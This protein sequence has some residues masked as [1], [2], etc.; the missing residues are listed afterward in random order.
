ML[1]DTIDKIIR[2]QNKNDW[3][4]CIELCRKVLDERKSFGFSDNFGIYLSLAISLLSIEE[5][6]LNNCE[7][8][9]EIYNKLLSQVEANTT[10]WGKLQKNLGYAYEVRIKGD[11]NKNKLKSIKY[12]KKALKV[13]QDMG[14]KESWAN[15]CAGI[16]HAY[17]NLD[18]VK[19]NL[20]ALKALQYFKN[21]LTVF[22]ESD[23][24]DE[25]EEVAEAIEICKKK[26]K[27]E[28]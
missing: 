14:D 2:M 8:A 22:S 25:Y 5:D 26:I 23:Y 7:E 17:L 10:Q 4:A 19:P 12:Y 21:S 16:G 13:Y 1:N 11:K 28:S 24:K 9:I 20:N 15:I 27:A 18:S 6:T 3:K